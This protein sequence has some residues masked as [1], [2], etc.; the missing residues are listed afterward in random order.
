MH[1]E[2]EKSDRKGEKAR[3]E[4]MSL[5]PL[6]LKSDEPTGRRMAMRQKK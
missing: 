2:R 4:D 3:V 5:V 6:E 1:D